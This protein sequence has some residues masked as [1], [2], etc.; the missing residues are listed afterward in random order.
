ME[1]V[2]TSLPLDAD[3]Q[4]ALKR[5]VGSYLPPG[6]A[7]EDL[8]QEVAVAVHRPLP[9][10]RDKCPLRAYVLRVAHNVCLR[11]VT[12][13]RARLRRELP[14]SPEVLAVDPRLGP[15]DRLARKQEHERLLST[16]RQLPLGQR[17]VVSLALEGLSGPEIALVLDLNDNAV[18]VRLHRARAQLKTLLEAP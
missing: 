2:S 6:A 14:E 8:A 7:R 5:V 12:R 17:Q 10:F 4:R 16:V 18:H 9:R 1:D 13:Q 3:L 15:E 11:Q